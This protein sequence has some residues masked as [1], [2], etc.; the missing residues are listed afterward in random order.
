MSALGTMA[1]G[2]NAR[3]ATAV[4]LLSFGVACTSGKTGAPGQPGP[5]GDAGTTGLP[6]PQ[7]PPG[8]P[9]PRGSQGPQGDPGPPGMQGSPGPKGDPGAPGMPA[10][11]GMLAFAADG[12]PLGPAY[13]V[14]GLRNTFGGG[15]APLMTVSAVA[16]ETWILLAEQPGGPGSIRALV[17]RS[18]STGEA[19]Y[20][21][22]AVGTL[23]FSGPGCTGSVYAFTFP[24]PGMACGVCTATDCR[25][26]TGRPGPPV[27]ARYWST[28]AIGGSCVTNQSEQEWASA[29]EL[30]DVGPMVNLSGP[31]QVVPQ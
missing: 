8:D 5:T 13:S 3:V 10:P 29:V 23:A 15:G 1:H 27:T 12:T 25:L 22:Q 28:F 30:L 19:S 14:M 16:S 20:C 4:L 7:G 2:R 9:G 26:A 31:L 11:G 6:G 24:T 21:H 17:W 18:A